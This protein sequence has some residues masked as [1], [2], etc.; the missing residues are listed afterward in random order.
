MHA[1]NT[2][3]L[4]HRNKYPEKCL[5]TAEKYKKKNYLYSCPRKCR[6]FYP[7]VILADRI[8]GVE[9]E[10]GRKRISSSLARK[11]K[12]P[13]S[14]MC[15]YVNSR[16]VITLVRSTYSCIRGSREPAHNIGVQQLQREDKDGLRLSQ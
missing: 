1:V 8:L 9:I 13:Y 12:H 7:Y 14:R 16:V 15:G 4:S 11:W 10:A 2:D 5:W 3:A 6:H